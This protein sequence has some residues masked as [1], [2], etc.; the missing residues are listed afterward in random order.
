MRHNFFRV[1][2]CV[3]ITSALLAEAGDSIKDKPTNLDNHGDMPMDGMESRPS[4]VDAATARQGNAPT[5]PPAAAAFGAT[6]NNNAATARGVVPVL[7]RSYDNLRSGANLNE[8]GLT[9]ANVAGL[10]KIFSLQPGDDARGC[11]AQPLLVPGVTTASGTRHDLCILCSM[12]N[13]VSAFDANDGTLLWVQH[14]GNPIPSSR[15]IDGW[16]INDHWGILSTPVI[17]PDTKTLYCVTWS[18]PNGN[19]QKAVHTFH[20]LNLANGS[21]VATPINFDSLTFNPGHGLPVQSFKASGRKQRAGLLLAKI[22]GHKTVFIAFGTIAETSATAHGWVV[23]VDVARNAVAAAWC[24]TS[25]YSGAGIWMA[26]QGPAI[27]ANGN[28]YVLT[29]NGSFDGITD[30]GECFL[31]LRYTPGVG[32]SA[33]K[34]TPVDWFSPFSD[35]GR[36]GGPA[37]GDHI[38]TDIGQGWDDMDLGAGGIV[39]IPSKGIIGGAGKDGIWYSLDQNHLG[40]T[41]PADFANPATNYARAKWIG[42]FTYYNPATP[43]PHDFTAL[44]QFYANRTHH[45]HST[46]VV[47]ESANHGTMLFCGGENGNVRAWTVNPGGSL[48]YL[49]CSAEVAS[50][51]SPVPHGG[52]PGFMLSLSANRNANAI[53]WATCPQNDANRGI[54]KGQ[55]YAYDAANLGTYSDGSGAIKLLWTSPQYTYNKF[56]PPVVSGA[57]VYVPT[58]DGRV[59]VYGLP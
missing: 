25:H 38:T 42:W 54:T 46:P 44:N 57:K 24:S 56:N 52:M 55:L 2:F 11:E 26:G 37:T 8:T 10:K 18:D 22:N 47:F 23:A 3:A 34:I 59:D 58:Y 15:N 1:C 50:P 21:H 35:S 4:G 48:K 14:L 7:T 51:Q 45:E 16:L 33:G 17:D 41:K 36:A 29:G 5:E 40:K 53:L 43:A 30:F 13:K 28:I 6:D 31:K 20:A 12:G 9:P 39:V 32:I 49:A 19:W 27:D